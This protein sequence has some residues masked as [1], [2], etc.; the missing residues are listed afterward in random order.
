MKKLM[1]L[2][3]CLAILAWA[4]QK[5]DEKV[6]PNIE[7]VP[8]LTAAE[9]EAANK[10]GALIPLSRFEEMKTR[11]QKGIGPD[12]VRAVSY[13]RTVLQKVLAQK[14]CVGIRFYF[15]KDKDG[16]QT[17]VFIGV[18]KDGKDIKSP[19]NAK[20]EGDASETGGDGPCCPRHC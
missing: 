12:D 17:L 16:K 6:K 19:V 4:C 9:E 18:D 7:E 1:I 11:F 8:P 20:I 2:V 5:E 10:M 14:G 13:G 15:A 3:A